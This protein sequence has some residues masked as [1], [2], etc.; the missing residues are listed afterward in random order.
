[1]VLRN[2]LE[3]SPAPSRPIER[4]FVVPGIAGTLPRLENTL[5]NIDGSSPAWLI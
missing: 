3:P 1:M 2:G 5:T 4:G